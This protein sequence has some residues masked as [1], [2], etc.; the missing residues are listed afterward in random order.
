MR[1]LEARYKGNLAVNKMDER[2]TVSNVQSEKME[3]KRRIESD[4]GNE[5]SSTLGVA[6]SSESQKKVFKKSKLFVTD[7]ERRFIDGKWMCKNGSDGFLIYEDDKWVAAIGDNLNEKWSNAVASS[8]Q[9]P[10]ECVVDGVKM[11]W[12]EHSQQW[13]PAVEVNEDFLANYH[14]NYGINYNFSA[15]TEGTSTRTSESESEISSKASSSKKPKIHDR[16]KE[17]GW[18]ELDET[19][20]ATVYITNLPKT[21]TEDAF[22]VSFSFCSM[23]LMSKCGVI[24]R[25]A[26]TNKLKVKIY[27]DEEG[28]PKGDARCGYIKMESVDLALQILDGWNFDGNV[29]HVEKAKFEMKGEFDPSKKRRKL[30]AAQKKRFIENQQRIFQWKPEKPRNY[31]PISDCTIVMKNMFS[32]EQMMANATLLLDLKEQMRKA[33]ERF[34]VVKKV[35]VHDNNPEGVICVTFG[36]VEQSDLAVRSLNGRVVGNRKIDVSLWDGKTKF[37][38]YVIYNRCFVSSTQFEA[39]I[40]ANANAQMKFHVMGQMRKR[41]NSGKSDWLYGRTTSVK[42]NASK[43]KLK[44]AESRPEMKPNSQS[45]VELELCLLIMCERNFA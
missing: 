8:T 42:T 30:T 10:Y 38:V 7:R 21:V 17:E 23:E 4:V 18:V 34:G 28:Q 40:T 37:T 20:N 44:L 26:R 14:A 12:N 31:R 25:D 15:N 11:E 45:C 19:K 9:N 43:R 35:V 22:I 6:S 41:K 2:S 39:F 33:C 27:R 3:E 13:L 16:S 1:H 24:Q 36:N 5:D 32:L 29:I